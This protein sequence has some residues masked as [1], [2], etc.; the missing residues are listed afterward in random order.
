MRIGG[1]D[2]QEGLDGVDLTRRGGQM[3]RRVAVPVTAAPDMSATQRNSMRRVGVLGDGVD[4]DVEVLAVQQPPDGAGPP[5]EGG[6]VQ[7]RLASGV[8]P[9]GRHPLLATAHA[10]GP[11]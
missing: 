5:G 8:A 6:F 3:E 4:V 7:G 10:H 11:S 2:L 9:I 1:V